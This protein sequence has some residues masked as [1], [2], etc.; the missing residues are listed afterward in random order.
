MMRS[1]ETRHERRSGGYDRRLPTLRYGFV[2]LAGII[3][4]RLFTLQVVDAAY[5]TAAA[6]DQFSFYSELAPERGKILAR[7][8]KDGQLYPVATNINLGLVFADPRNVKDVHAESETIGA[9][10]GMTDEDRALLADKLAENKQKQWLVIQKNVPEELL[11]QIDLAKKEGKLA[12]ISYHRVPSRTYPETGFSGHVL[13]FVGSNE[14]GSLTGKYGLEGYFDEM[15]TGVR[16]FLDSEQDA[17]GRFIVGGDRLF[18]PAVD[19]ADIVLTID[20]NIEYTVCK[21]LSQAVLRHGAD[22][23]SVIILNPSTGAVLAM[24]GSPGFDPNR[25]NEVD[26]INTFNNPATFNAY[27]PGSIFKPITMAAAL[28]TGAVTPATTFVDTGSV[29]IDDRTIGNA[30]DKVYGEQNM[31][32]VL[33]ESINTGMIFTQQQM[34]K[35]AFK[36]YVQNF[37]FGAYTGIELSKEVPGNV[38]SLEKKGDVFAATASFGQGITVTPIQMAQAFAALA[39][40]GTLMQPYI[41]EEKRMADGTVEK[42]T[43]I[44]I[45]RVITDKTANLISAMLISVVENGHGKRAGVPGYYI[46]GKTGTAQV[47]G[48]AGSYLEGVTIGSFAGYGPVGD[49]KFAMVVRIDHPRDV[50]YAESTAAPLFGE[51]ADFLLR[52]FEVPPQR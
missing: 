44:Q 9:I 25:Y 29:T 5:Y 3:V 18:Q 30:D 40:G 33:E 11:A 51:I 43:P 17:A 41:V 32:Q 2:A 1:R 16:G 35:E 21:M 12:G 34:G 31:T 13:G 38:S 37:G 26:D 46:A 42:T 28:D 15:L 10:L 39:N 14:D 23:G 6:T 45:R 4:L 50:Q 52:Y 49:P 20:R 47:A 27:E 8:L 24:C 48:S 7:D 36:T 19:G 22:G